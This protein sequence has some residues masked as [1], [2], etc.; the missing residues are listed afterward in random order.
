MLNIRHILLTIDTRRLN[1]LITHVTIVITLLTNWA[2]WSKRLLNSPTLQVLAL[3]ED[4]APSNDPGPRDPAARR[5]AST[6]PT[7]TCRTVSFPRRP[8][9]VPPR[10]AGSAVATSRE[11]GS[12]GDRRA[13]QVSD[14]DGDMEYWRH[15]LGYISML[16]GPQPG[17]HRYLAIHAHV[18]ETVTD[19][20]RDMSMED[21]SRMVLAFVRFVSLMIAEVG[22]AIDPG[23]TDSV[24]LLR[25]A[26]PPRSRSSPFN[27]WPT[28][29]ALRIRL[30]RLPRMR[31][32]LP[33]QAL[34]RWRTTSFLNTWRLS[35]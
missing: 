9:A 3:V 31:R 35:S 16:E 29:V 24:A 2:K 7:S 30:R 11:T 34:P 15:L 20:F 18:A 4:A 13:L 1:T 27:I 17:D 32:T 10:S 22:R 14:H 12:S 25:T 28:T 8:T 5:G 33:L 23:R 21:R 19:N 6:V 26:A